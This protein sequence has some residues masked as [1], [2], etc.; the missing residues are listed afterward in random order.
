MAKRKTR[1]WL[2]DRTIDLGMINALNLCD[3]RVLLIYACDASDNLVAIK[4]DDVAAIAGYSYRTVQRSIRALENNRTMKRLTKNTG[5][6]GVLT[7]YRLFPDP[8]FEYG[9]DGRFWIPVWFVNSDLFRTLGL[10]ETRV[11]L[12]YTR[13]SNT[14]G[15]IFWS[16][17]KIAN[18]VNLSSRSVQRALRRLCSL[19][20]MQRVS[21]GLGGYKRPTT[22]RLLFRAWLGYKDG[23][24]VDQTGDS[25]GPDPWDKGDTGDRVS[26]SE[27]STKGDT[28][29]G[30][31][32][33]KGR[34]TGSKTPTNDVVKHDRAMSPEG[35]KKEF[36]SGESSIGN[37]DAGRH[38]A[39]HQMRQEH[40]DQGGHEVNSQD[41]GPLAAFDM[42]GWEAASGGRAL[43][44]QQTKTRAREQIEA[45]KRY[46]ATTTEGAAL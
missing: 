20:L 22:Y 39:A 32:N 24:I 36:I 25:Y 17:D 40:N 16:I 9:P 1:F 5:G 37:K 46:Q 30:V 44:E 35:S 43:N 27:L 14:D 29:D 45:L 21:R 18:M 28:D 42:I 2:P 26:E 6:R 31:S 11:I 41:A 13:L 8:H 10:A 3:T 23:A 12:T 7:E 33:R 34:Q 19:G 38:A 4:T 15:E